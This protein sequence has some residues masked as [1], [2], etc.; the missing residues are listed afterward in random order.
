[1]RTIIINEG[2]RRRRWT[3][4]ATSLLIAAS[5]HAGDSHQYTIS[6]DAS[7]SKMTVAARFSTAV[8]EISARSEDAPQ[9]L[10]AAYDCD[11]G[12]KLDTRGRRLV[13]PKAGITCLHYRVDLREG[14]NSGRLSRILDPA[15]IVVSPTLWMWR[16][17][18]SA[19]DEIHVQFRLPDNVQVSV[20]W[21]PL[22]D[23]D[24]SFRLVA[25]PQSGIAIAVFGAF[26]TVVVDVA[27]TALRIAILNSRSDVDTPA[28][29]EW[30]R[31]TA[32]IIALAYGRFPNTSA[33]IV[34]IP[35]GVS[36]WGGDSAV[37]FGRVVRDGGETIEL[38][39][40][41]QRPVSE[42]YGAWTAT[43][44]FSHLLLPYVQRGQRWISEGFAQYYQNLL[45][46]RAGQYTEIHAWQ[47]LVDGFERGR[48]SAPD[49]SPNAATA[50]GER[51]ARMKIYWSGAALAL[52]AD[53][54]LRRRSGGGES[55]DIVLDRMQQCCLPSA[56]T[57]SGVDLFRKFDTL[58]DEPLFMDL[59]RQY[60][61][62][63][64]FPDI[65]RLLE[66]LGV[67]AEGGE[68][69]LSDDAELA[70]IRR[71]LTIPDPRTSKRATD[72]R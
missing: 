71:A 50:D 53:V 65:R 17:R 55:L 16:P 72:E 32:G 39:I 14:A 38:F 25:S 27:G 28:V 8:T 54:E 60:A 40:N 57:W 2:L 67:R 7:L 31:E 43:H 48:Q 64:G 58:V 15:N 37:P 21:Q 22:N 1:M 20:P 42:Y 13:L 56:G 46:A 70:T 35:V 9:I 12:E 36:L 68:V 69:R 59:Y 23:V 66:Q 44:E 4:A 11:A 47:E 26:D 62:A 49:R 33:R 34:V 19:A 52:M 6:V 30:V 29:A 45:L 61:D 5:T 41:E 18:L 51:S 24:N 63:T 10:D 3:I